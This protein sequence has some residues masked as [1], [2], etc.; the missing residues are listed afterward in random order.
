MKPPEHNIINFE[1]IS[2][3]ISLVLLFLI[4]NN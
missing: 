3:I 1:Q 2:N 4:L